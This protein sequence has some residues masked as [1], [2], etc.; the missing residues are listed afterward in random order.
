[1]FG[2][3]NSNEMEKLS[4]SEKAIIAFAVIVGIF[5]LITMLTFFIR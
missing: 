4:F 2:K 3:T 1:M 5:Y